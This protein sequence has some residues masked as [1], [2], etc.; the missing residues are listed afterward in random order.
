MLPDL[1]EHYHIYLVDCYGHGKSS[2]DPEKY[3]AAAMGEDFIW[4]IESIIGEPA[5]VSGHS[6]GGLMTVWLAANAPEDVRGIVLEDPPLFSTEPDRRE[7]TFAW[8]DSHQPIHMFLNQSEETDFVIYYLE[9][10]LWLTYFG[11]GKDGIISYAKNYRTQHPDTYLSISFLP[12]SI[13]HTYRFMDSY[14]PRFGDM[15][16][17]GTWF[18]GFDQADALSR[19]TCPSVLIHASFQ[20]DENGVLMGA[21]SDEDAARAH[22]L[23]KGNDLVDVV[24]GH[25]VHMEEPGIFS[26][27]LI[28]FLSEIN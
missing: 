19:I 18:G 10:C 4:F 21:M 7:K 25:D 6:S 17:D 11:D 13:N 15:F 1:S 9:H 20:Y 23:I 16:Y 26:D 12:P 3:S 22:E 24:S 8:V 2:H 5:V 27:I 28:D 14:D